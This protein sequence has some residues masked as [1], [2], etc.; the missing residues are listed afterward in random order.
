MGEYQDR[1]KLGILFDTFSPFDM[2]DITHPISHF[3]IVLQS[4]S[5]HPWLV[6]RAIQLDK[7]KAG[8]YCVS[9][10]QKQSQKNIIIDSHIPFI[11][12]ANQPLFI[13][14]KK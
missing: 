7:S 12:G 6:R 3:L 10:F 5:Q 9:I 2:E 8:S 4:L 11:R 1:G 14:D 13:A